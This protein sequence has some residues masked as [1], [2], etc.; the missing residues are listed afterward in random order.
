MQAP[1]DGEKVG[2]GLGRGLGEGLGAGGVGIRLVVGLGEGRGGGVGQG[3]GFLVAGGRGV[4][5]ANSPR[6]ALDA[7]CK[8]APFSS[9]AL[10]APDAAFGQEEPRRLTS[11]QP[12]PES[13][14]RASKNIRTRAKLISIVVLMR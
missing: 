11:P 4:G 5:L 7:P 14:P 2:V 1:V 9:S 12:Q 10:S 13:K 6:P 3:R 8:V